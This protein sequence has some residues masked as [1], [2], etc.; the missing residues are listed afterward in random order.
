MKQIIPAIVL[1]ALVSPSCDKLKDAANKGRSVL[2]RELAGSSGKDTDKAD[3][4]LEKLV[5][6]TEEGVVFRMDLPFPKALE[7][8]MTS[9]D[10]V[11]G[12]VFEKSEIGSG[13]S[14]MKGTITTVAILKRSS[15][16]V[17]Y[18]LVESTFAKP[19]TEGQKPD[20][21]EKHQVTAPF[22]AAVRKEGAVWKPL[23]NDFNTANLVQSISPVFD[24]VLVDNALAP[25]PMWFGKKRFKIGDTV[26]VSGKSLPM[27]VT[28]NASGNMELK[29]ESFSAVAGHPCAVFSVRGNFSRK[30]F[31][32]FDGSLTDEE[33]SI[34]TGKLW[35]S[36]LYPIVLKEQE[37]SIRSIKGGGGGHSVQLNGTSK[38]TVTREWK[39]QGQTVAAG[40]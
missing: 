24:Q 18:Q 35:L 31:P 20:Q 13:G 6:R 39:P 22:T 30:G 2:E 3:P 28:G 11:D 38:F 21:Q 23:S 32:S 15:N 9:V 19:L 27:I 4:E 29:L 14:S 36:L 5:D 17:S 25:H 40:Q 26:T 16:H 10:E 33:R 1:F 37:N 7:V 12:R 34:E 8:R